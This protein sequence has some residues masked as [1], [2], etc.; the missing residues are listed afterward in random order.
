[1]KSNLN[2]EQTIIV[3]ICTAI[4]LLT[5]S[6]FLFIDARKQ[7]HNYW[8]WGILGLIQA[9]VPLLV[10]LLAFRKIWKKGRNLEQ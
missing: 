5:Q 1:M 10:Y 4:I 2:P 8:V 7:G 3:I 6:I 9:P